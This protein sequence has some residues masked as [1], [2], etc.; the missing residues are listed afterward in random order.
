MPS[1]IING[2]NLYWELTG[3]HGDPLY[4]FMVPG[5]TI[6]TGIV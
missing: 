5:V 3:S 2:V 4:S 1:G 6:I